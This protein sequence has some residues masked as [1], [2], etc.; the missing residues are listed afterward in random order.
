MI[1]EF[2]DCGNYRGSLQ[3]YE[4][5]DGKFFWRVYCDVE[6]SLWEE[7]PAYVW[8]ALKKHHDEM[9]RRKG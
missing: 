2:P 5:E 9:E 7:I 1:I 6:D 4:D 3:A 8:N